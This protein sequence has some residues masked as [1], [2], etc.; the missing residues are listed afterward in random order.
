[1]LH[2]EYKLID[3]WPFTGLIYNSK[4]CLHKILNNFHDNYTFI[5]RVTLVDKDKQLI[6]VVV[7]SPP[8]DIKD[9]KNENVISILKTIKERNKSPHIV[10]NGDLLS[11]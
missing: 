4:Y 9:I 3:N 6:I 10:F 7:Y 8:T 1:M 11:H 2:Y 5:C